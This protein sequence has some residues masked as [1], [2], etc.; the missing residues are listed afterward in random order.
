[1]LH[2]PGMWMTFPE[3]GARAPAEEDHL[4]GAQGQRPFWQPSA[5]FG[6]LRG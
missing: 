4:P 3:N 2:H 5:L 1:M 6:G